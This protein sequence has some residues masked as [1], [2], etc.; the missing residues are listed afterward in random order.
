MTRRP[1][2]AW[3]AL[4]LLG[5]GAPAASAVAPDEDPLVVCPT[6]I[7]DMNMA[8]WVVKRGRRGDVYNEAVALATDQFVKNHAAG[9]SIW[10]QEALRRAI[11]AFPPEV[12]QRG[13]V[14]C[15]GIKAPV[16]ELE[17]LQREI[18]ARYDKTEALAHEIH[19]RAGAAPVRV[20]TRWASG[21]VPGLDGYIEGEL[22][23]MLSELH[24]HA[25][26]VTTD[27]PGT[28]AQVSIE[29]SEL[30]G[31]VTS[32]WV[33]R[34]PG[35]SATGVG[36][37]E[38][39]A[40]ILRAEAADG[41]CLDNGS[42]GLPTSHRAGA[43]GLEV[44]MDAHLPDRACEG[45]VAELDLG[46]STPAVL[47]LYSIAANGEG[48]LVWPPIAEA[49]M[50]VSTFPLKSFPIVP[51]P[52]RLDER[53]VVV[54][55]PPGIAPTSVG[56]GGN[57]RLPRGFTADLAPMGAAFSTDVW[58]TIAAGGPGCEGV[59]PSPHRVDLR[60]LPDCW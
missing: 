7:P 40:D 42:M 45:T 38:F 36:R 43:D 13:R 55:F 39:N 16:A 31:Q 10:R 33:M 44:W 25:W 14:V 59:A 3:G 8:D 30:K 56:L 11:T 54:A 27:P 60:T 46:V 20:N 5:S 19:E 2:V 47:R 18:D 9:L 22:R 32:T 23:G 50:V 52:D 48:F 15:A 37:V 57:C 4:L 49:N 41:Q 1:R 28:E 53:L 21:C 12:P 29:F 34:L 24:Y 51:T 26:D 6:D 35:A 17:R 58:R